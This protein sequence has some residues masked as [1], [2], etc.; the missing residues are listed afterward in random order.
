[1]QFARQVLV[2]NYPPPILPNFTEIHQCFW[3]IMCHVILLCNH[4]RL[5]ASKC[6]EEFLFMW[7]TL[8]RAEW[9]TRLPLP[10]QNQSSH[11]K[12]ELD[13][14]PSRFSEI[15]LLPYSKTEFYELCAEIDAYRVSVKYVSSCILIESISRLKF[16]PW[17]QTAHTS[18]SLNRYRIVCKLLPKVNNSWYISL[19]WAIHYCILFIRL[20]YINKRESWHSVKRLAGVGMGLDSRQNYSVRHLIQT[21][22]VPTQSALEGYRRVFTQPNGV[23]LWI[24]SSKQANIMA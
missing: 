19:K 2:Y 6:R 3:R 15:A 14:H 13:S 16:Q 24:L 1:M 5:R 21:T 18:P 9:S 17:Q 23:T 7:R 8:L 22:S 12:H 10:L 20:L 4:T 11:Y